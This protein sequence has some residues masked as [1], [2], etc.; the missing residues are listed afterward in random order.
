MEVDVYFKTESSEE[1]RN[2]EFF[3]E[4]TL[5]YHLKHYKAIRHIQV[6]QLAY[7]NYE[8]NKT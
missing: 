5:E 3:E 7:L 6:K 1:L 2:A 8:K 4:Y